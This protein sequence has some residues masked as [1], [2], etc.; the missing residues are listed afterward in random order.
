[1]SPWTVQGL[2]EQRHAEL[3][4][5]RSGPRRDL[6]GCVRWTHHCGAGVWAWMGYRMIGLG[7]RMARPALVAQARAGA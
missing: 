6:A 7:C 1:M 2:V 4:R 3:C 5:D